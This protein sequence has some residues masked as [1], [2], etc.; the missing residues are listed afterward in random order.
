MYAVEWSYYNKFE[1][2]NNEWLPARGEGDNAGIQAVTA[3]NKLVYKWYNDGDVFDNTHALK[4]W[5]NDLS[6][7][8][9]WLA[10][11]AK[12][13]HDIL[14]RINTIKNEGEY[15]LLLKDLADLVFDEEY[16][17]ALIKEYEGEKVGSIYDCDG[18]FECSEYD[19]EEE[20]EYD[21]DED[22]YD[23]D[24]EEDD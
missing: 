11:Y 8:A 16:L 24:D 4:G 15:E 13:C 18:E 5:C 2:L 19:D 21:E 9:N 10:E 20:D 3:V 22:E 1:G 6:S 14:F 17:K 23:E 7:Y 12:G